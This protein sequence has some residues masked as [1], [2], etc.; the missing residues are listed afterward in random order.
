M[1]IEIKSVVNSDDDAFSKLKYYALN[2]SIPAE[3]KK[4]II[5]AQIRE[6]VS[7]YE[8]EILIEKISTRDE[9]VATR[10]ERVATRDERVATRDERVEKESLLRELAQANQKFKDCML[11]YNDLAPRA[12]IEYV[13]YF[14][15]KKE[16]FK[17]NSYW[18][19]DKLKQRSKL[20]EVFMT[21]TEVG[22]SIYLCLKK[23]NPGWVPVNEKNFSERIS[24]SYRFSC[25][26][27]HND[28]LKIKSSQEVV[29]TEL[30]HSLDIINLVKCIATALSLKISSPFED[31][32]DSNV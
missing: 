6:I 9:R 32:E 5:D 25:S 14:V 3:L 27:Y 31:K 4:V 17:V 2:E 10:D 15:A 24:S 12:V 23:S 30:N 26:K 21:E 16:I 20:W 8:K 28:S 29:F 1:S 7:K 13:E 11:E 19:E 18:T 22:K